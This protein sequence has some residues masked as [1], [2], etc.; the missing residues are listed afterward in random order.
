[1]YA[2]HVPGGD[3]SAG[4]AF[5]ESAMGNLLEVAKRLGIIIAYDTGRG[6][7]VWFHGRPGPALRALRDA[8]LSLMQ[9]NVESTR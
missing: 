7:V 3:N 9:A 4:S 6:V 8:V 5:D 2:Y 1:M